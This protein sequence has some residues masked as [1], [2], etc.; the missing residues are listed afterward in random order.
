MP[1]AVD[2]KRKW[3]W[4]GHTLLENQIISPGNLRLIT[5]K[6]LNELT[7]QNILGKQ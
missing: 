4:I 7:D 2:I 3:R 6:N 1:V 5:L